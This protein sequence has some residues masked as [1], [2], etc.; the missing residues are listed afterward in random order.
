MD[1]RII[2]N[3]TEEHFKSLQSSLKSIE[4]TQQEDGGFHA[5]FKSSEKGKKTSAWCTI[6]VLLLHRKANFL[7]EE[8]VSKVLNYLI[9]SFCIYKRDEQRIL[10]GWGDVSD[11]SKKPPIPIITSNGLLAIA[12]LQHCHKRLFALFKAT[13]CSYIE[14]QNKE[15]GF[16]DISDDTYT[17]MFA[18]ICL[19]DIKNL[20]G[21]GIISKAIGYSLNKQKEYL[22]SI[23]HEE[24]TTSQLPFYYIM[25]T[26]HGNIIKDFKIPDSLEFIL[27]YDRRNKTYEGQGNF[28]FS[29]VSLIYYLLLATIDDLFFNKHADFVDSVIKLVFENK[30]P[31][32]FWCLEENGDAKDCIWLTSDIVRIL[33]MFYYKRVKPKNTFYNDNCITYFNQPIYI[34]FIQATK[35]FLKAK[36]DLESVIGLYEKWFKDV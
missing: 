6:S 9:N 23:S 36:R 5:P 12:G 18:S 3:F 29:K 24:L 13:L 14:M 1:H 30:Q 20:F 33:Y 2:K 17:N 22:A 21:D 25:A 34:S 27:D 19:N 15:N 28:G 31:N 8:S 35:F 16:W 11:L 32:G 7:S 4:K 26:L 10:F